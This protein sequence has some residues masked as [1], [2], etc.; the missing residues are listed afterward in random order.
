MLST[1]EPESPSLMMFK[2]KLD[3]FLVGL[4]YKNT[5]LHT[6]GRTTWAERSSPA[7][8][9]K[10]LQETEIIAD[11]WASSIIVHKFIIATNTI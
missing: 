9:P 3:T 7:E 11:Q 5:M 8:Q 1:D 4:L 10:L 6:G 2:N